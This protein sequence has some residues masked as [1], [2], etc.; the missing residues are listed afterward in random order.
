MLLLALL[1]AAVTRASTNV[2]FAPEEED[3]G[4]SYTQSFEK[5]ATLAENNN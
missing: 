2:V 4:E 5:I 3:S 1:A